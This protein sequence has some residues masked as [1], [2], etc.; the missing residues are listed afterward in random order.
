M[1]NLLITGGLGFIGSNFINTVFKKGI[2][3]IINLDAEIN[4]NNE[5]IIDPYIR[6]SPCYTF[7]KGNFGDRELV[8]KILNEYKIEYVLDLA[9]LV[10]RAN[11]FEHPIPYAQNNVLNTCIFLET[12][13]DYGKLKLFLT[14]S[15]MFTDIVK[16]VNYNRQNNFKYLNAYSVSKSNALDWMILYRDVYKMPIIIAFGEAIIGKEQCMPALVMD[17]LKL[18]QCDKK[19]DININDTTKLNYVYIT[20]VVSALDILLD[21]GSSKFVYEI[22]D[23]QNSYYTDTQIAEL[24]VKFYKKTTD[25]KKW[26]NYINSPQHFNERLYP[27]DNNRLLKLGWEIKISAEQGL[28][29]I[30]N[31]FDETHSK[32]DC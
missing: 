26:I 10:L 9:A 32:C 29:I 14:M 21:R 15:T 18:L 28:K 17:Y 25:Y 12:C 7:I 5:T 30:A 4:C 2:F 1:K 3:R 22:I 16:S 13:R 23:K 31:T 20:N 19:I 27:H 11:M 8:T 6:A 24:L